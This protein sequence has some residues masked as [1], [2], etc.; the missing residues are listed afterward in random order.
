MEEITQL[1]RKLLEIIEAKVLVMRQQNFEQAASLRDQE[2]AVKDQILQLE[3]DAARENQ[4]LMTYET[5]V[6]KIDDLIVQKA[7]ETA[8]KNYI[9]AAKLRD[10]IRKY[11]EILEDLS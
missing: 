1:R 6:Q 5:L 7:I 11:T 8:C 2:R 9:E 3:T 4:T 10:E